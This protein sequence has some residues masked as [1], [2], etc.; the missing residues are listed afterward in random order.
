MSPAITGTVR[1]GVVELEGD[2]TLPEGTQVE[3]TIKEGIAPPAKGSPAAVLRLLREMQSTPED[4]DA[5]V[6]AMRAGD[7]PA[8]VG[9]VFDRANEPA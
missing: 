2:V 4:V 1:G 9:G 7:K 5:L 6:A 8:A 3:V